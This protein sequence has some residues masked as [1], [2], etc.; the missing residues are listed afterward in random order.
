MTPLLI[1]A[2]TP[3]D[4]SDASG[5]EPAAEDVLLADGRIAARGRD[6]A[7]A[8]A[9]ARRLR[10]E[11]LLVAPGFIDLQV[12]GA[13]GHDLTADPESVWSIGTA[14]AQYGVTAFLP[15]I[16]T[17]P[18]EVA[19]AACRVVAAGPPAGYRGAHV[20]GLHLEGPF[21]NPDRRGAHDPSHLR[22]PD[23]AR[24]AA[25]SAA[26]GVRLVTLAPELPGAP[27]LVADLVG[28][29]VVVSA[30][31]STASGEQATRGFDA[32]IRYVTHLFNG[33][34]KEPHGTGLAAAALRDPRV[35]V[36]LIADGIHVDAALLEAAWRAAGPDRFSAVTDAM[37]ALGMPAGRYPLAGAE[38]DVGEAGA[39]LADGRLAGS[40]LS[41]D[42]AVR[43]LAA[44]MG[45]TP[46]SAIGAVTHVPA[47]LLGERDRGS[48]RPGA[49][50]DVTLLTTRLEV[51]ATIAA[52][53]VIH[54]DG[55]DRWA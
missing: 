52:G 25:W 42:T 51:V 21:L 38:V 47:R 39:R 40:V 18:A 24:A 44:W 32:G 12:N 48:L 2:G 13:A 20:L 37:A 31:H 15:T 55:G 10:A 41:L 33:M 53:R 29:G 35:T 28:R 49:I 27:E 46:A 43:N 16:V 45:T 4:A 1:Q 3:V 36:G 7:A 22:L 6:A 11:G 8:G 26:G 50:A 14:L 5:S 54:D 23:A 19:D 9:G 30:G 34:S 17:S